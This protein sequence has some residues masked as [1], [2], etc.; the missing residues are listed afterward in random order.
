MRHIQPERLCTEFKSEWD[1]QII[2]IADE[3]FVYDTT[4]IEGQVEVDS[5]L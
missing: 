4:I 2:D 5:H 1:L 3:Y